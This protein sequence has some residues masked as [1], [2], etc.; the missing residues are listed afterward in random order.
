MKPSTSNAVSSRSSNERPN[1][2]SRASNPGNQEDVHA[3]QA[4]QAR[5]R[6]PWR[7]G[8]SSPSNQHSTAAPQAPLASII[9][10]GFKVV[11][12]SKLQTAK[13]RTCNRSTQSSAIVNPRSAAAASRA[14]VYNGPTS[15]NNSSSHYKQSCLP[16]DERDPALF[17]AERN[18]GTTL[19][20]ESFKTGM[21][22]R[23]VLHEPDFQ[24]AAKASDITEADKCRT[25]TVHGAI[26][27]KTRKM[28]VVATFKDNYIAVPLYTHNGRGLEGKTNPEEYISVQDHRV[29]GN[30]TPLSIHRPLVTE[31]LNDG[32]D[33]FH[34]KTAVHI[35]YLVSRKYTLPV[36]KE[37]SL[38]RESVR[39]L[40]QLLGNYM[41][42]FLNLKA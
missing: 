21:V 31:Q 24:R 37:G 26:Y 14:N 33:F 13:A 40:S 1:N 10:D 36:V 28:I 20:R 11:S 34:P 29:P 12:R 15:I 8:A 6:N 5:T 22:I 4:R 35:T 18:K 25:N 17:E 38:K 30:L 16:A 9:E 32:I 41:I 39:F 2:G 7:V 42:P 27:T 19:P 3:R 23:A